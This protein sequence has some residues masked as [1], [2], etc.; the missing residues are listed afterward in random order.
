MTSFSLNYLLNVLFPDAVTLGLGLQY[1]N[2]GTRSVH[3]SIFLVM[4]PIQFSCGSQSPR[5]S[6]ERVG[7]LSQGY[8]EVSTSVDATANRCTDFSGFFCAPCLPS[9][10]VSLS[11]SPCVFLCLFLCLP[12]SL[13]FSNSLCISYTHTHTHTHTN[14]HLSRT[15]I[16]SQSQQILSQGAQIQMLPGPGR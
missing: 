6:W 2:L 10:M 5:G 1:M 15:N 9:D 3:S 12:L 4:C 14:S 13:P 11:L 16:N 7:S 8:C